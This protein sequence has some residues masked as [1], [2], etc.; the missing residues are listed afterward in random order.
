MSA[1]LEATGSSHITAP[2][3][4]AAK[5]PNPWRAQSLKPVTAVER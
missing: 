1:D 2:R 5:F 3:I 4:H